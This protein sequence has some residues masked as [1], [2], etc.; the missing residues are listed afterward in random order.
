MC[1]YSLIYY[2]VSIGG[3]TRL[4]ARRLPRSSFG[5]GKSSRIASACEGVEL[6]DEDT[7]VDV[8]GYRGRLS[9][10]IRFI[11]STSPRLEV[12]TCESA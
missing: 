3:Q 7:V 6:V 11:T 5:L 10:P 12:G 8:V 9:V 4:L 2:L 1:Y